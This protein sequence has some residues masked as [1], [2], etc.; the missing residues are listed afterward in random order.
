MMQKTWEQI[1]KAASE[2]EN[3]QL[4]ADEDAALET[5]QRFNKKM[6]K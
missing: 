6:K 2:T 5:I 4:N 1:D 3:K